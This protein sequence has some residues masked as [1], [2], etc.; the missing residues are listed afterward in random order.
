MVGSLC[1]RCINSIIC[2][3]I[4]IIP[5]VMW[6][7]PFVLDV[8]TLLCVYI[9]II[10]NVMWLVPFFADVLTLLYVYIYIYYP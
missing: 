1:C 9:Y 2:I 10:P 5:N 3:Y 7:I 6:L 4:Y 8:L